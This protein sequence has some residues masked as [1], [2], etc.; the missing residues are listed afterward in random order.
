MF[1]YNIATVC[2]NIV[3]IVMHHNYVIIATKVSFCN[4]VACTILPEIKLNHMLLLMA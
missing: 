2:G 1:G 3:V 4:I